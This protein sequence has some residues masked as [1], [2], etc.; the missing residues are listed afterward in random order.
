MKAKT[1]NKV[2]DDRIL[3]IQNTL[4]SKGKEYAAEGRDRLENF[5][6][7]SERQRIS[8]EKAL[9]LMREKHEV[10][11][12]DIIDDMGKGIKPSLAMI[13]EKLGDSIAYSILLESMIKE[14]CGYVTDDMWD[15]KSK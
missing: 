9:L 8:R 1:F 11:I 4:L 3:K 12:I 14:D 2:V 6:R 15:K 10:S 5:I 7:V 13:E